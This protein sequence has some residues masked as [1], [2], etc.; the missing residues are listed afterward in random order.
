MISVNENKLILVEVRDDLQLVDRF[1]GITYAAIQALQDLLPHGN[2][3]KIVQ[4]L[5]ILNK[6]LFCHLQS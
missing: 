5:L 6:Y 1:G 3:N 4:R 2:V